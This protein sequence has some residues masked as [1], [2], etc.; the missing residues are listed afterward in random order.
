MPR[1]RE[2]SRNFWRWSI[3]AML[4]GVFGLFAIVALNLPPTTDPLTACRVDKKNPAHTVILIDQSDPFAPNDFGWV[5]AFVDQEARDLPKYGRL[6]IMTPNVKDPFAPREVFS[7]CSTGSADHANPFL[8]NPRM[9]ED[10]WRASFRE[11][12]NGAVMSVLKD[13]A[14]PASPLAEAIH[15]IFD[16]ADFSAK[17]KKRR[18]VIISDLIQNSKNF[19][20]YRTGADFE[21]FSTSRLASEMHDSGGAEVVARIVPRQNYDLPLSEVKAFWASYFSATNARFSSVN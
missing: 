18:V 10:N 13:K 9:I 4:G 5:E 2:K 3:I 8:E 20:F 19:N 6:T 16:R 1:K 21:T 17:S 14:A 11:P 7:R 12:L 15:T